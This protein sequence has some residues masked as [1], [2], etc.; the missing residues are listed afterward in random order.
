M[1]NSRSNETLVTLELENYFRTFP[2]LASGRATQMSV[3][4]RTHG[5]M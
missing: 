1:A 3:L 5:L 2:V 4:P